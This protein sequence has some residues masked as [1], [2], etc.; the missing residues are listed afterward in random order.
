MRPGREGSPDI[1]TFGGQLTSH[2]PMFVEPHI[3]GHTHT[4]T[5]TLTLRVC[6]C[7]CV[8]VCVQILDERNILKYID[9]M[10]C[11]GV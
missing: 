5:H 1:V 11:L 10:Y 9:E 3:T 2:F 7:V 8:C 4:H 6:V